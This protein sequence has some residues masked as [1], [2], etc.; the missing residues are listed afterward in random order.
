M[1][2]FLSSR[3]CISKN[4]FFH[5]YQALTKCLILVTFDRFRRRSSGIKGGYQ[6]TDHQFRKFSRS[7]QQDKRRNKDKE[8]KFNT[9]CLSLTDFQPTIHTGK[10]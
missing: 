8:K 1:K 4:L 2:P 10:L 6:L 5:S 7:Y 3:H 9:A